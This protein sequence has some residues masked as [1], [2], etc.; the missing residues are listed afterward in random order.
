M[1]NTLPRLRRQSPI[2]CLVA[3]LAVQILTMGFGQADRRP[4]FKWRSDRDITIR[5]VLSVEIKEDKIT[6]LA[7]AH[8]PKA[9]ALPYLG[10][11][12]HLI[13]KRPPLHYNDAALKKR[14]ASP[15]RGALAKELDLK[16]FKLHRAQLWKST[17]AA[18]RALKKGG[19]IEHIAYFKPEAEKTGDYITSMQGYGFIFP[20]A[21]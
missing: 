5:E 10:K 1:K 18:A 16:Q 11:Q 8:E 19:K 9:P 15:Q 21:K 13:I 12:I 4:E 3:V 17:V 6:I 20:K 14:K 7:K 2:R